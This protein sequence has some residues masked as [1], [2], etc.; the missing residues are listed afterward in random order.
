[1]ARRAPFF[2]PLRSFRGQAFCGKRTTPTF[3][4]SYC[5][6]S[7]TPSCSKALV[8]VAL[9]A[10]HPLP[11]SPRFHGEWGWERPPSILGMD[12]PE[13]GG[14]CRPSCR[15]RGRSQPAPAARVIPAGRQ[16]RVL[17]P[18]ALRPS[19]TRPVR[20]IIPITAPYLTL[21]YGA[22]PGP[23]DVRILGLQRATACPVDRLRQVLLRPSSGAHRHDEPDH[24]SRSPARRPPHT[25][26]TE[27][28]RQKTHATPARG[29]SGRLRNPQPSRIPISPGRHFPT[30]TRHRPAAPLYPLDKR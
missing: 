1:M 5:R 10:P 17:A 19:W 20:L 23:A 22:F 25:G 27:R 13:T 24:H 12:G 14:F 7:Q 26:T 21:R 9:R 16:L 11:H 28:L 15:L 8:P 29:A 6:F 2:R 4:R 18:P 30:A 3:C